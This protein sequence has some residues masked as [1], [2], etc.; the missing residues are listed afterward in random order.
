GVDIFDG[1]AIQQRIHFELRE[2]DSL[3]VLLS[4]D[5][6]KYLEDIKQKSKA[7]E[8]YFDNYLNGYHVPSI[9]N[10]DIKL[11]DKLSYTKQFITLNRKDTLNAVSTLEKELLIDPVTSFDLGEFVYS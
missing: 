6:S 11:L 9:I 5:H 7:I 1:T 10:L 4:Q 8:F 3:L 2:K